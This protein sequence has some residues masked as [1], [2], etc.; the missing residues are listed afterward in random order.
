MRGVRDQAM[1]RAKAKGIPY[2]LALSE[3]AAEVWR[4]NG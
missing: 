4:K 3:V 2:K 1:A